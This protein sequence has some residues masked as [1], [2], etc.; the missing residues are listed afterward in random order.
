MESFSDNDD[1]FDNI[2]DSNIMT[3]MR[4][5]SV[6][7][8]ISCNSQSHDE[9]GSET[10]KLLRRKDELERRHKMAERHQ[11]RLQVSFC[12]FFFD[13]SFL[14]QKINNINLSKPKI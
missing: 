6:S 9:N 1:D 12:C 7:S 2:K 13:I 14:H 4:S 8:D 3:N 5:D 10:R 11:Q